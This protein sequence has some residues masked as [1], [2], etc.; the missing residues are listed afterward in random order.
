MKIQVGFKV[1]GL[2]QSLVHILEINDDDR[3]N[4]DM[5]GEL[6]T[7]ELQQ[8]PIKETNEVLVLDKILYAIQQDN[9][10]T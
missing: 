6:I 8:N 5:L 3:Y 9:I 2:V 1:K 10:P 7:K 4:T